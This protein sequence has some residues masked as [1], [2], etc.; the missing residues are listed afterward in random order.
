MRALAMV[1]SS[2]I[3]FCWGVGATAQDMTSEQLIEIFNR[4]VEA[5][6][7]PLTRSIG[8]TRSLSMITVEDIQA[9]PVVVEEAPAVAAVAPAEDAPSTGLQPLAPTTPNNTPLRPVQP[10][11]SGGG[12]T[13]AGSSTPLRPSASAVPD[14]NVPLLYAKLK[15]ELQVNLNIQFGFDSAALSASEAPKLATLCAAIQGSDI[16]KFRIIGHTDTS[17]SDDYNQRLSM[18]RAKEVARHLVQQC[19][20]AAARL[21][22]VGMGERF[23]SNAENTRADE[24]RRVEFQALS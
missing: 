1:L 10:A 11:A 24:N 3:P 21:E 4:Q 17:G 2:A 19:G 15:P 8:G 23:P 13:V 12:V 22:T 6:N 18:L 16:V 20:I 5:Q 9:E 14:P 7:Q